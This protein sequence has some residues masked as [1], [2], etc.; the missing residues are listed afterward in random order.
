LRQ[1]RKTLNGL[2]AAARTAIMTKL[3]AYAADPPSVAGSVT[4]L[5]GFPHLRMRVGDYRV[6]FDEDTMTVL[7]VEVG[8]RKDIYR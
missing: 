3:E 4:K 8:H 7:V 2:P 6:I 5:V 1:A